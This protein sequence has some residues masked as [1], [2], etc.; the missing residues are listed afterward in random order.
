MNG[1]P[2]VPQPKLAMP[3]RVQIAARNLTMHAYQPAHLFVGE[4]KLKLV[5]ESGDPW[6]VTLRHAGMAS[7]ADGSFV[8]RAT[9]ATLDEAVAL[10]LG[11]GDVLAAIQRLGAALDT[12]TGVIR[13]QG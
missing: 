9:A 8:G 3:L 11:H 7:W 12:L 10:A 6:C 1:G 5:A 4:R 13:A 2:T